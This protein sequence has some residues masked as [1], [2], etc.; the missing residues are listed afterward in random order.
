MLISGP[1]F[2]PQHAAA[3]E[4]ARR[5]PGASVV[6]LDGPGPGPGPGSGSGPQHEAADRTEITELLRA[7]PGPVL[8]PV[9]PRDP[10]SLRVLL[11][12]VLALGHDVRHVV[13]VRTLDDVRRKLGHGK[14]ATRGN[15]PLRGAASWADLAPCVE[16]K[17]LTVAELAD[18][19][20]AT[21]GLGRP[22]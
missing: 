21:V 12:P 19:V 13:L 2:G 15:L 17:G 8:A 22:E 1:P 5:L 10:S 7:A 11:V 20:A 9:T 6:R 4:L 18:A 3:E 14:E 16:T